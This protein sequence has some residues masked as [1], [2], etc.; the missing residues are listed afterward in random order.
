M[1]LHKYLENIELTE[2]KSIFNSL[3]LE[4]KKNYDILFSKI[5]N[6]FESTSMGGIWCLYIDHYIKEYYQTLCILNDINYNK[7]LYRRIGNDMNKKY[8]LKMYSF[9]VNGKG[10]YLNLDKNKNLSKIKNTQE[11][12]LYKFGDN[13]LDLLLIQT[14]HSELINI[15]NELL[16]IIYHYLY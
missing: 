14:K 10:M 6:K 7:M 8:K 9:S 2:F 11:L 1:D 12:F 15:P 5:V 13:I 4:D 3:E 16:S